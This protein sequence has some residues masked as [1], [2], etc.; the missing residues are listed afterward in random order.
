MAASARQIYRCTLNKVLPKVGLVRVQVVAQRTIVNLIHHL[1]PP[2][3]QRK[4]KVA[5]KSLQLVQVEDVSLYVTHHSDGRKAPL[6]VTVEV[7]RTHLAEPLQQF[8]RHGTL[9][10]NVAHLCQV[11]G[12]LCLALLD[13]HETL[14]LHET[15]CLQQPKAT[16]QRHRRS[17]RDVRTLLESI[18]NKRAVPRRSAWWHSH[19]PH[20]RHTT[21]RRQQRAEGW[22]CGRCELTWWRLLVIIACGV[23]GGRGTRWLVSDSEAVAP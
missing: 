14:Q 16:R 19:H 21:G 15:R 5:S 20:D 23:A 2:L 4:P 17:L 10:G 8:S 11:L 6:G 18:L 12:E 13:A 7:V 9:V 3:D 1:E 22:W